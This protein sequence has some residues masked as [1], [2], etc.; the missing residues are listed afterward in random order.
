MDD[1]LNW[2]D[3]GGEDQA[4]KLLPPADYTGE[5]TAAQFAHADWAAKKM[6][7]S[8]G[9]ILKVKVEID[10]PAGYGV[11]ETTIPVVKT[12]RWK[13]RLI[14]LAAGVEPPSK[15]GP[16]WS[17]SALVGKRV[18]VTTSIY[19]NERTGE[20]KVQI[21]KWHEGAVQAAPSSRPAETRA[22]P[23]SKPAS[24]PTMPANDDIPF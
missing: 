18:R 3:F 14:S 23:A 1:A 4:E 17:P 8:G 24:K 7:E 16:A 2:D 22:K 11:A 10:S 12:N 9:R 21:D 15:D 20:S 19:T 5:I 13:F 6:P